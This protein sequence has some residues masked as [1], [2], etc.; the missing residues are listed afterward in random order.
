[1]RALLAAVFAWVLGGAT[2]S[3]DQ[4]GA[5]D[6][7]VLALSWN[8]AWCAVEGEARGA[9]QCD[10]RHDRGFTLHGLWPQHEDGWPE[11]CAT[12]AQD[13]SRAETGGE[14]DLYGSGGLAWHQWKKHGR[15][16]GLSSKDYFALAREAYRRVERPEVLRQLDRPVELPARVVEEAFLESNPDL[17]GPG[18]AIRCREGLVYEVRVCLTRGLQPRACSASAARDCRGTATLL[19]MR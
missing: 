14:A 12:R 6:Y 7:Y 16:S 13:P 1:M 2:A 5:F 19:P 17:S 9:E 3:A 10:P 4:A 8:A 18:V 11:Y 15:C